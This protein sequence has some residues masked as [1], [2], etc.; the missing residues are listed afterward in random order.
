MEL[1]WLVQV[2]GNQDYIEFL[3]DRDDAA[4]VFAGTCK[5]RALNDVA[6]NIIPIK[7]EK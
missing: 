4:T 3:F 7:K 5:Q 2:K 1:R 6:I